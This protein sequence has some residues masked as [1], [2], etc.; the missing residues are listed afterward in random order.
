MIFASVLAAAMALDVLFHSEDSSLISCAHSGSGIV[1]CALGR[2][3]GFIFRATLRVNACS[4][5]L[6]DA[7][8]TLW[9]M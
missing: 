4:T 3:Y 1:F 9:E 2:L 8:H 6:I 5:I 7:K